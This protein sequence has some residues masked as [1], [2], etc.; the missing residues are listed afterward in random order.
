MV[1][2][3]HISECLLSVS[4][5]H[6]YTYTVHVHILTV[7]VTDQ[8]LPLFTHSSSSSTCLVG[9]LSLA[10]VRGSEGSSGLLNSK[11]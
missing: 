7:A 11:T 10:P 1:W 5:H 6:A 4:V 3:V 8:S 2:Y 9:L